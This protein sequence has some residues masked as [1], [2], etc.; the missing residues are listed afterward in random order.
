[1]KER[2]TKT[3]ESYLIQNKDVLT[4]EEIKDIENKLDL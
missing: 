2:I 4:K 3:L 1:M